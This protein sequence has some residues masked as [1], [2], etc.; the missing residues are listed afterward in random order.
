VG[1]LGRT[2]PPDAVNDAE[3][4]FLAAAAIERESGTLLAEISGQ[5]A[6]PTR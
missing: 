4:R 2:K 3:S 6:L 1:S 5:I